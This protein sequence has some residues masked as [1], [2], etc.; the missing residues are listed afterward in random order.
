MENSSEYFDKEQMPI[1]SSSLIVNVASVNNKFGPLKDFMSKFDLIG[2]T[3][4]KLLIVAEMVSP[5]YNLINIVEAKLHPLG[6]M[7]KIDY[8]IVEERL[9]RGGGNTY[10][11]YSNRSNPECKNIIWLG[12]VIQADGNFVWYKKTSEKENKAPINLPIEE[13]DET[14]YEEISLNR[15]MKNLRAKKYALR[16]TKTNKKTARE[17][18]EEYT[19]KLSNLDD[20]GFINLFNSHVGLRYFN[21]ALQGCYWALRD[22][23]KKR[24]INYSAIGDEKGLSFANKIKLVGNKVVII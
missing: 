2:Q 16:N 5:P 17:Y 22:E 10:A 15:E 12:S 11:S 1:V 7:D 19:E 4:G 23:F 24:D 6:F 8:V 3:N 20:N 14:I 21:I 9:I 18:K 13:E